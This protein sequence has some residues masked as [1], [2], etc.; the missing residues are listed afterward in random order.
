[1][2]KRIITLYDSYEGKLREF[3]PLTPHQVDI[4]YC[5]PTV[6]NYVHLGNFR[7]TITFDLLTRFLK[8]DGYE[9]RCVSN[10]TDIDD[11]IIRQ[12]KEERKTEKELSEFY[13]K[14]YEDCLDKLNILPLYAHPKASEYIDKMT[15]FIFDLLSD[16]SA[17]QAGDDTFFRVR[18]V[19]EY[20]TLSKQRVDDLE[21]GAR[22][23]VDSKKEDPLDFALW[24]KTDDEG[25][26]FDTKIG[27]GRPGWHTECVVMVN[28]V[29]HKPLIDIH[30]GGFD[31]KFPHHENEIAQSEAHNHTRLADYWMHVGFLLTDGVK[32]SKSLGNSILAKDILSRHSGNAIRLFFLSTHYRAPVNYTEEALDSFDR[33]VKKYE[34]TLKKATYT[35]ALA[36]QNQGVMIPED[37][38]A[39]MNALANDLNVAN[40]LTVIDR[41]MKEINSLTMKKETDLNRLSDLTVT[42]AKLCDILGFAFSIPELTAQDRE[43]YR[44]YQEARANKDYETSDRYRPSLMEKGIL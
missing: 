42:F 4:Y 37:D 15:D 44:L 13:I 8:A 20:G 6:Y 31:L 32:M 2:S 19:P 18:S 40:A 27:L 21:S 24:K 1:M 33:Q 11:K 23:D 14:A 34:N 41:E 16:G 26:K 43:N 22:I 3:V 9:V 12:A 17:Y 36:S 28:N 39:F 35:L 38:D 7:P 25:I 29:F 5:G 10:Y 30:G